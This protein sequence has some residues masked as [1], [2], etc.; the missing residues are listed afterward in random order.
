VG[1]NFGE[2]HFDGV[3]IRRIRR[4][5]QEPR[6]NLLE[7]GFGFLALVNAKIVED[8][9]VVWFECRSKLGFYIGVEDGPVHGAVDDPWRGQSEAS[10]ACDEGLCPPVTKRRVRDEPLT[11]LRAATQ[12]HHLGVDGGFIQ[13]NKPMR[14]KSH[15]WLTFCDPEIA[16]L[17]NIS[18]C[19]FRCPQLFFYM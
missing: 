7:A 1:F 3:Q 16:D 8:D 10:L 6:T 13:K 9:N 12:S 14:F 17:A 5:K 19:A 2:G 18:A 15:S 11:A 4:Q